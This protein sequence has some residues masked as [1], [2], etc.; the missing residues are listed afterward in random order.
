MSRVTP[1][2]LQRKRIGEIPLLQSIAQRLGFPQLL[3]RYIKPHGNEK[4]AAADTLLMLVFNIA[5]GRQPLYELEHWTAQLDGRLLGR[6]SQLP[7]ALF[8][9]DRYGR[10]LDKLFAVDRASLMTDVVLQVIAATDLDLQQIHNDSTSVKTTGKMPG[11][12]RTGLFFARGHSKDH[13]PDLKQIVFNL[14]L[15]ADGAVPIHYKTYPGN[16]TDDTTHIDTWRVIRNIAGQPDFLYVADCKV[17]T[18]KQLSFIVRHGGRVVTLLPATWKEVKTF[19]ESL[20]AH[21]KAK[22]RILRRPIPPA[23]HAVE[24]FYCFTGRYRTNQ[25]GYALHWIYSSEKRKRDRLQRAQLLQRV[26]QELGELMGKLNAR[27]LK[28]EAQ[29]ME[30]LDQLLRRHQVSEFYH[31]AITPIQETSTQQVGKGRPGKHT[32]Y[33]TTV[34]TIYSLSWARNQP[35]LARE[36]NIDGIFPILSTDA[37][38][39]AREALVAYKYQPRLEKRFQQLKNVHQAAPTLFKKVERVEAMMFL[40]FLALIIQAVI[41]REVRQSMSDNAIDAIP[42]YPEHRLAYHPTTA[43]IF[44]RFHDTSLYRVYQEQMLVKEYR[45]ELTPVQ[46]SVLGLLGMTEKDYWRRLTQ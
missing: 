18:A 11:K 14:T 16:R 46:Q 44:D 7:A 38:M 31:I 33:R 3:M 42:I 1:E 28:T 2:K 43:K 45:D 37:A 19:K 27:K 17:C 25:A 41:E 12:S 39:S 13:R 36:K 32:R 29:I 35:A 9:D 20:R 40:F 24:T 15:S 30:R 26:E 22:R 10:A 21:P 4:I 34:R 23:E 6:D 8:N 5:S